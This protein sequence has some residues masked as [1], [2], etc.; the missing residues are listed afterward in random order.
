MLKLLETMK[1]DL[2]LKGYSSKTVEAYLRYTRNF[3]DYYQKPI[4]QLHTD[5]IRNYLHYLIVIKKCSHS[6]VNVNYSALKFLYKN[7]LNQQWNIDKIPRMKKEKKLPVILSKTEVK[8]ILNATTN[9]KHKAILTTVYSAGLRISEVRSLTIKDIDSNNMQ[10]RVRKAKGKK[11]RYTLLSQNNLSLLRKYWEKYQPEY[12]LFPGMPTTK[13]ISARTI[14]QFFKKYLN[15]TKIT[16][17]A[18]V[19]TL[20]HCFATHLLEAGVDI[21][22]IQKLLGHASPKTTARYIH[23][24]RK[25]IIDVKSPFDMMDSDYN[26]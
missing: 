9:L 21:F 25:D 15:K 12:L 7:T 8:N 22:H 4:E 3:L 18:T 20:R 2:E 14:Q 11:D 24:T 5:E 17:N 1:V 19:H 26:D 16:K 13:A 6:Y 10:I 23:L